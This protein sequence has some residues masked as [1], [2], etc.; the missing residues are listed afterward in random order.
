M[1][2]PIEPDAPPPADTASAPKT[3]TGWWRR[4]AWR[5]VA[6]AG[7][8]IVTLGSFSG[9]VWFAY[10]RGV[11]QGLRLTP[12]LI[13]AEPGPVKV[14]PLDPGG[15]DVPNQDRLV[16]EA[17]EDPDVPQRVEQ[18]L[19]P[20][21]EPDAPALAALR[22][23]PGFP[24]RGDEEAGAAAGGA[25]AVEP[26]A[27]PPA[28]TPLDPPRE[29]ED[30]PP[31]PALPAAPAVGAAV[32][33][34]SPRPA[35]E[36]P[37]VAPPAPEPAAVA[38][39]APPEP[40]NPVLAGVRVQI[41]AYAEREDALAGWTVAQRRYGEILTGLQPGI[42]E[43]AVAGQGRRYRLQAGPLPNAGA[44]EA[45]CARLRAAGGDCAVIAP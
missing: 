8:A 4:V 5:R 25:P 45:I 43:I 18:L 42:D 27:S 19:P 44:A 37:P 29:G 24:P 12:P 39:A 7:I 16:F 15:L 23:A 38:A 22:N 21:E 41:G 3:G 28:D 31:P 26:A 1:A 33:A 11:Q 13:R 10:D 17:L 30:Q 9:A 34:P 32:A 36:E 35:D 40:A 20:P 14:E 2:G 6:P